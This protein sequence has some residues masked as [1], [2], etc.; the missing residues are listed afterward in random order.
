MTQEILLANSFFSYFFV[1][2]ESL[3]VVLAFSILAVIF[4]GFI[5]WFVRD[6]TKD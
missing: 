4:G 2:G 6:L 5:Y 3:K 1:V